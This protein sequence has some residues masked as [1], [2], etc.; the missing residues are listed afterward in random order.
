MGNS[1]WRH[2][3]FRLLWAGDTISQFGASISM[4]A[5]PLLAAT[6]LA[7]T[8]FPMGGLA[9]AENAAFLLIGLPAGVWVDRMRRRGLMITADFGRAALLATIPIAWWL[10]VLTDRKSTRLDS[11]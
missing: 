9:A 11:S 3:D 6:V 8:P 4:V 2:R 10:E 5:I 1:L 7:A